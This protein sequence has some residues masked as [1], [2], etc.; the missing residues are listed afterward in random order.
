MTLKTTS[1][2]LTT[3]AWVKFVF[4]GSILR[5]AQ[6]MESMK[7]PALRSTSINHRMPLPS[8]ASQRRRQWKNLFVIRRS[9]LCNS[10]PLRHSLYSHSLYSRNLYSRNLCNSLHSQC[11]S[12]SLFSSRSRYNNR[13]RSLNRLR[14]SPLRVLSQSRSQSQNRLLKS[15][16]VKKR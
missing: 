5:P 11:I 10:S 3:T 9:S 1:T 16:S 13:S 4:I 7:P 14:H 15:R 12:H 8:R 2:V 6:R